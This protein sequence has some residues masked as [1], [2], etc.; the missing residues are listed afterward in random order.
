MLR[1]SFIASAS[2]AA[3]LSTGVARAID[4][5]VRKAP[6]RMH[7]SLAAYSMRKYLAETKDPADKIDL[8]Q[9]VDFCQE[10]GLSGAE[11]TSYYFPKDV[12]DGYIADLKR[13][14]HL[15]G[16]SVSG[17]AI[18]NDFCQADTDKLAADIAHTKLWIDRYSLLGAPV[19]RIFA[20]GQPAEERWETVLPRCVAAIEEVCRYAESRGIM[21]ALENHGGVTATA[22]SLLEI[23]RGVNSRAFGVNFDSG[24]FRDTSEPYVELTEIAPFAVNAQLKVEMYPAGKR[25]PADLSRVLGILGQAGYHGWV[26]LEYEADED[27]RTAIPRYVA[28]I[29]KLLAG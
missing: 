22:K 29:Q 12:N 11:L 19:I 6:G 16:I 8:M 15:R 28:E 7:L 9:F 4:P 25:E 21:L 14:C 2:A 18:A 5:F 24:N 23:V 27:P 17:G 1:R 20:G 3:V 13:H 26:V 10:L